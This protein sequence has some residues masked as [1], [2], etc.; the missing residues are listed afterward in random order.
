MGI[1][2]LM[3][4]L[5]SEAPGSF[6]ETEKKSY[7]GR[8]IAFDASMALYA[9]LIQIRSSGPGGLAPAQNLTAADGS[10]TSHIQGFFHRTIALMSK[11][12]RPIY[13]FD[14]KPPDLKINELSKRKAS[15]QD[16]AEK[17][18]EAQENL[19]KIKSEGEAAPPEAAQIAL[20]ELNKQAKRTTRVTSEHNEDVQ[21]L[22]SLMGL[23]VVIAP[24][25]VSIFQF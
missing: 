13:V 3:K 22:L 24:G 23:P 2:Q 1:K 9:M 5:S 8:T 7:V 6:K 12:I 11:G 25:E 16:A 20:T 14:G 18:K 19:E 4:L 10:V 15:K 17:V 21:K